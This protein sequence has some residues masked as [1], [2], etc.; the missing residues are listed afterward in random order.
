VFEGDLVDGRFE[1]E[2]TK[3]WGAGPANMVTR[4]LIE[5]R[6]GDPPK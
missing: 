1:S 6:G 3:V 5:E 4:I 2:E